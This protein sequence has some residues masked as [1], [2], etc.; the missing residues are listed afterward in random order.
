MP[1]HDLCIKNRGQAYCRISLLTFVTVF[2]GFFDYI[3]T[4]RSYLFLTAE[5][6]KVNNWL[7]AIDPAANC[8][9]LVQVSV[10]TPLPVK[11]LDRYFDPGEK[12]PA[13]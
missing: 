12:L 2:I 11:N 7:T 6:F 3:I 4:V 9:L 5:F 13:N 10:N 8:K 1:P